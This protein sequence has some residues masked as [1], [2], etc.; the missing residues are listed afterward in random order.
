MET[1]RSKYG[2]NANLFTDEQLWDYVKKQ[3]DLLDQTATHLEVAWEELYNR[4]LSD[5]K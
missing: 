3:T 1:D 5:H 4:G 2:I